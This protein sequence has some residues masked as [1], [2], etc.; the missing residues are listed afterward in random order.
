M[1]RLKAAPPKRGGRR[2][3]RFPTIGKKFRRF[4]NDW[5]NFLRFFK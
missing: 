5:K 2:V 3:G 1:A 4:S